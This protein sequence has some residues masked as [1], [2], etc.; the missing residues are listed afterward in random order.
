MKTLLIFISLLL[1]HSLACAQ[2]YEWVD[3]KGQTHFQD[4]P[5]GTQEGGIAIDES[6]VHKDDVR[7]QEKNTNKL[8]HDMEKARKQRDK[9]RHKELAKQRKHDEKCLK[10]RSQ[11]RKLEARMQ[12]H[13]HEFSNDRPPS[14]ERQQAELKDRKQYLDEYCN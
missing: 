5:R 7:K 14:Y 12:K 2:V 10:L 6:P 9:Q 11:M 13:Y 4:H 1:F 3:D 8:I